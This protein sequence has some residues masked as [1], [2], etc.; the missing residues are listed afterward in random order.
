M[1]TWNSP[2]DARFRLPNGGISHF[3]SQTTPFPMDPAG[4]PSRFHV[5]TSVRS[6]SYVMDETQAPS[7]NERPLQ[8]G[9][10]EQEQP[11]RRRLNRPFSACTTCRKLKTRCETASRDTC[12]RCA[13][14]RF[15]TTSPIKL[16]LLTREV[17]SNATYQH[18][19]RKRSH[20]S[21]PC[22]LALRPASRVSRR[23]SKSSQ[24]Y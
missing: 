11:K 24:S 16:L 2:L 21:R 3:R 22:L 19:S 13:A 18:W 20:Q 6:F 14:L 17:V 12:R 5:L 1:D 23:A 4:L 10:L 7:P 9:H 8:D 15:G